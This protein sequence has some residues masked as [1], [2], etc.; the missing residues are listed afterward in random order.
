MNKSEKKQKN[1]FQFLTD[2]LAENNIKDRDKV[3][4][5]FSKKVFV[6]EIITK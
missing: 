5:K 3:N 6:I 2:W 1:V 4:I